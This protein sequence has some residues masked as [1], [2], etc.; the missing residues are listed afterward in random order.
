MDVNYRALYAKYR[1]HMTGVLRGQVMSEAAFI[2]MASASAEKLRMISLP[3]G[4]QDGF[5]LY[6]AWHD[7]IDHVSVPVWGCAAE[8]GRTAVQL[9]QKLADETVGQCPCEFSVNLYS[10][11]LACLQ[12]FWRMQFGMMSEKCLKALG[13]PAEDEKGAWELRVLDK[14]E[15]RA[16]WS[17]VWDATSRIVAHLRES[18]VFYPGEEF[19]EDVYRAFYLAEDT[20]LIA[21][22]DR[23]RLVGIIEWNREA[24]EL[25][26]SEGLSVNV[27]EAYVFPTYRGT[28]LAQQL[29][30][31]AERAAW[32]VGA[33]WMWVQHGTANPNACGFWNK[34]ME[35][36]QVEL[37]RTIG[38]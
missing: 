12:A 34:T 2:A 14:S 23:G 16:R 32:N 26:P 1:A 28:G 10:R 21:A 15:L 30:R 6:E 27:G 18:P 37:V 33:R 19:T 7:T 9:F 20:E 17:E 24:E 8:S 4:G 35:P 5:L 13:T 25:I 3:E 36:Y 31:S 29:L 22:F 38:G 11:D